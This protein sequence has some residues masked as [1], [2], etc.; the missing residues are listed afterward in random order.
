MRQQVGLTLYRNVVL[1]LL[2]VVLAFTPV[3]RAV[4]IDW[5][6]VGDPSNLGDSTVALDGT[7][8]QGSVSYNYSISKYD[9]TV[10]QYT[11]FL[12]AVAKTDTYALYNTAMATNL[13]SAGIDRSGSAGSYT[14]SVIGS[15]ADLPVT[16]VSFGDAARFAN[17]LQNGQPGLETG[18]GV[19][20]DIHSTEDGAY[21]LNGTLSSGALTAINRNSFARFAIPT[22]NEWYKAAYYNASTSSYHPYPLGSDT[23]PV[24]A[25]PGSTANTGNFKSSST[26]YAV[27]GSTNLSAVKII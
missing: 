11:D 7:H 4:T 14:Y 13:H 16:Y 25:P 19:P 9:V 20:Q 6:P 12:N 17:W 2:L 23:V 26:G 15:S 5:V 18:A 27:T 10:G 24:S 8:G 22:A 21:L 1:T 3:A